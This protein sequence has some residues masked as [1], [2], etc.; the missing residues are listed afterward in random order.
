[1]FSNLCV[2]FRCYQFRFAD[3]FDILLMLVGTIMAIGN[4]AVLPAMVIVFGEMT[5]SFVEDSMAGI[6]PPNISL[7]SESNKQFL[8]DYEH[9]L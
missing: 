5:N 8:C 2:S 6:L 7:Q 1:M 4:G 3:S 9:L